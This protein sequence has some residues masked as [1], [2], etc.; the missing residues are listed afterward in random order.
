[1]E[2]VTRDGRL[3]L[4]KVGPLGGF[5][6]NAYVIADSNTNDAVIIDAPAESE[7]A[8]AAAK[9]LNVRQIIVTHRHPDHWAGIETLLA[10][11][12]APVYTHE[13]DREP[14]A[15]YVKGTLDDGE[16]VEVGSLKLRVIHTPGHTPGSFCLRLG[17]HL[18]SGDTLFPGGPGR[19]RSPELLAQEIESIVSRLHTLPDSLHV[20]PGHGANTTI[21]ESKAEYAVFAGKQHDPNLSGDVLWLKS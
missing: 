7:Q 18:I 21:A 8:V 2:E 5:A 6:N 1:M 17:E 12:E 3:L 14:Y 13:A 15:A 16:E 19:T 11:I 10:G 4:I 9:G 20:Y